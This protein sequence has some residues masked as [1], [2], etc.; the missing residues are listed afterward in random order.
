MVNKP[1]G[2]RLIRRTA[3]EKTRERILGEIDDY[4]RVDLREV[5]AVD[6]ESIATG[7]YSPLTGF[8]MS[9]EL[10]SVLVDMRLPDDVPWTIPVVLDINKEKKTFDEG[11]AVILYHNDRPMARMFVDDMFGFDRKEYAKSVFRTTDEAH[12]GVQRVNQME[13]LLLGGE[14]ELLN[15]LENPYK[16][17]TLTPAETRLLFKEKKWDTIVAFQTRNV[18]HV[19]HEFLQKT[20]ATF[21]DGLFIN[22]VIG[23]K[24][25]GDFRDDVILKAYDELIRNYYPKDITHMSIL[26]YEM[27]YAGPKEAIHHAI[28]R[29]NFGCTHII[30]GRDHAG[31]GSYYGPFDAQQIFKE[32]PDLGMEAMGFPAFFYCHKCENIVNSKICPHDKEFH[33]F[34]S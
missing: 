21:V 15:D 29:K 19:G 5:N 11:D 27:K 8:M 22:P 30:I 25:P 6:V 28:M 12:P 3:P 18:A 26:R 34:L 1:H 20:A 33:D 23:K 24:K 13:D 31:V 14:I 16:D 32:F 2:G 17:N 10:Q 9:D 7:V 4:P